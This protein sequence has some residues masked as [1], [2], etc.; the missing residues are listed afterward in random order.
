MPK[1]G[2]CLKCGSWGLNYCKQ[3]DSL[4]W[5]LGRY[6]FSVLAFFILLIEER[7]QRNKY[8]KHFHM[9]IQ[10]GLHACWV[11]R[12]SHILRSKDGAVSAEV[13]TCKSQNPFLTSLSRKESNERLLSWSVTLCKGQRFTLQSSLLAVIVIFSSAVSLQWV[14]PITKR[15]K[16]VYLN[17]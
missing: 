11:A 16:K 5:C 12:P 9:H 4:E 14:L 15:T 8:M 13:L 17:Y 2:S 10:G 6:T 1:F 3:K 7:R